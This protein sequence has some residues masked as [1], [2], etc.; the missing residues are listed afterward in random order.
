MGVAFTMLFT[1]AQNS[2]KAGKNPADDLPP[3]ITRLTWFGERA[4]WSHDGKK[5]L[6]VE[7][8]Y[9]DAYEVELATKIVRPVTHHYHHLGYTRALYLSNGDIL[10]SGAEA[11][12]PKKP[13][14]SRVQCY[15]YVLD[16]SLSKPA[17]PLGTKCSEGPAVSRKRLHIAWT[18]VSAQYPDKLPSSVSQMHEADIVYE[19]GIPKLTNQRLILDSRDLPFKCTLETQNFRPPDEREL[20]FSAYG[21]QGTDVC[22]IDLMT[23]KVINYSNT[24]NQYDEPEGIFPDGQFTLVECDR[25]NRKGSGYVDLWKLKLDGSGHTERLTYF[26]DYTGYKASNPAVS[27]DGRFIAFQM[28]KSR[29]PAGVG[30][31]ILIYDIARGTL[32]R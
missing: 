15:L 18:H 17:V 12:D 20:T 9:G 25:Q 32:G 14:T 8:T 3:H 28:A 22:G 11:F 5:I 1:Q 6:F 19:N 24:P 4:D 13:H 29:D 10:L 26:S 23:K 27:D 30:Y 31:G 2:D 16:K 21:H 7:K